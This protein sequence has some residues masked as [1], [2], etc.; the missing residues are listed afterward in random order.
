VKEST[1]S[2]HESGGAEI[3]FRK[4]T[5]SVHGE[6]TVDGETIAEMVAGNIGATLAIV[7]DVT[8]GGRSGSM[9]VVRG[10]KAIFRALGIVINDVEEIT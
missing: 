9:Q 3:N 6:L 10:R 2:R 4:L 7:K 8:I 5:A 1:Q